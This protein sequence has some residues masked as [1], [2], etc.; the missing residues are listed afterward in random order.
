[1]SNHNNLNLK[2]RNKS[3]LKWVEKCKWKRNKI[4]QSGR[5]D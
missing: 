4:K 1:M 2:I 5:F 3:K